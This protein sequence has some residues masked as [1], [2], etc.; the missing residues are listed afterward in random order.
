MFSEINR[1]SIG[2]EKGELVKKWMQTLPMTGVSQICRKKKSGLEGQQ[3]KV[4]IDTNLN[5]NRFSLVLAAS[6]S[7]NAYFGL[8]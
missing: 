2:T 6:K 4:N 7:E 3:S 5:H 1:N 8:D